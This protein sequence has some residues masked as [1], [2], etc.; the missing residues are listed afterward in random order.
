MKTTVIRNAAWVVAWNDALGR[1]QYMRDVDVAFTGNQISHVG[2][3]YDGPVDAEIPGGDVMVMPGLVN[4]HSH[5]TSEPLR[6]GITDE[7]RSPNFYHSSLYEYLTIFNND[8]EGTPPCHKVA[9]AELLQS[10]CTTIVDYSMPFDG[11]LDLLAEA[12]IRACVAPSFRDAPWYTKDGHLLEYDWSDPERGP[13]GFEVAKRTIDL[14]N[15]HPS[16]RL[17]GMMSPAQ[18]DTLSP[19]L[20]RQAHDYAEERNLPFQIHAAQ[21]VNEFVEMVRRHGKTPIRWMDDMG[22]LTDRSIIGHG[23]FLD[24]H[25]WLHWSTRED[26]DLLAER[27]VTVAHCPTVFMRRGIALNTLGGYLKAGVNIGIGTDTYPHNILDEMRNAAT[28]ARAVAGTVDDLNTSDIFEAATIGGAK[29]LRRDDIGRLAVGA[30]ADL[31]LVD[32][33]N[34]AM[35]PLREPLRSLLYVAAERA[36]R[37]VYV[38]GRLVVEGGKCL[39][40][41]LDAELTALE[42]AQQRSMARVPEIDFANRTADEMA[43]MVYDVH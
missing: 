3:G 10:G 25:P 40:I 20:L 2:G 36:V 43:P 21:S 28:V 34:Q 9:M 18:V 29:A 39:T 35:R 11:W 30:K 38:D 27:G 15:Q 1:H 19:E 13:K 16:G 32:L 33:K 31:V 7:T 37:D 5:P 14:A 26:L 17:T 41:D 24:H 12:G 22:V 8:P 4:I 42:A 6:K 23:I